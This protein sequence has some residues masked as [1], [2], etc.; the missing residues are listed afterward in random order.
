MDTNIK[1]V[2]SVNTAEIA[3]KG[4]EIYQKQLK[5]SLE[6]D[7]YGKFTAIEVDSKEYFLGETQI[8]ALQKAKAKYPKK[9]FYLVRIGFPAVIT[10]S[11]HFKPADYENI[12]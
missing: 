5:E 11:R 7:H 3:R 9:I 1:N 6:R 12:L 2:T 8:D 4:E 10:M